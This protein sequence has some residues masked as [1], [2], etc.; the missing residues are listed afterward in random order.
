MRVNIDI[1]GVRMTR[2]LPVM[3]RAVGRVE[4]GQVLE[5]LS[6]D[7]ESVHASDDPPLDLRLDGDAYRFV[8]PARRHPRGGRGL[9]TAP[10]CLRRMEHG[11]DVSTRG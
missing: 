9:H 6:S 2:A 11:D 10:G 3:S 5:I 7:P 8:N 1:R 4:D